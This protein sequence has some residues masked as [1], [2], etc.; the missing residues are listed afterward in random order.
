MSDQ[1][2]IDLE[3]EKNQSFELG[4][5]SQ[6]ESISEELRERAGDLWANS[7]R[8]DSKK[9]NELKQLAKEYEERAKKRRE[10]YEQEYKND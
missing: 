7:S 5:I 3:R 4:H 1:E 9:A 6:L 2:E 8:H 10:Q